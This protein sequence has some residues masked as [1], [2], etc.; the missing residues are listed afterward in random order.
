MHVN[1]F[2]VEIGGMYVWIYL[3]ATLGTCKLFLVIII[4]PFLFSTSTP[5]YFISFDFLLH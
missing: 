3:N 1:R 5:L 4:F 2:L